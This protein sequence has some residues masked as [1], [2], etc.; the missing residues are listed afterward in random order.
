MNTIKSITLIQEDYKKLLWLVLILTI[1]ILPMKAQDLH[2]SQFW[3]VPLELNPA[4][5][6]LSSADMRFFG[7]YKS[8]WASVPVGYTTFS[9]AF[10]RKWQRLTDENQQ[11]GYGFLLHHDQ[12]GDS[13]WSLFNASGMLSYTKRMATGVY[14][15]VGGQLGFGQ[16]S[17]ETQDLQFDNQYN[18]EFFDPRESNGENFTNT[19]KL[20]LDTHVG[21][22]IRLQKDQLKAKQRVTDFDERMDN[23]TKLDIGISFHHLNTPNQSFFDDSTLD[24]PIRYDIYG[25]GV[26]KVSNKFDILGNGLVRLQAEFKEILLG[27]ALRI[28]LNHK[29]TKELSIDIGANIRLGDAAIP[30]IGMSFRNQWQAGF[31]YDINTSPFRTATNNNGGPELTLVYL[32]NNPKKPFGKICPLF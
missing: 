19:K 17:F 16:R 24:I 25:L 9:G 22:N 21:F 14:A 11:F 26:L 3:N 29:R 30:Y 18:G 12:A 20:F 7:G 10:D 4:L 1:G 31:V 27:A 2:F 15:S 8:Q 5:A 13:Q 6:G 23:R 28:Y 32:F